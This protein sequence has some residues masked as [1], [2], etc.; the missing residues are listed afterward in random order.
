MLKTESKRFSLQPRKLQ[1]SVRPL[2]KKKG[3]TLENNTKYIQESPYSGS[4]AM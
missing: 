1:K 2:N 3:E 4:E